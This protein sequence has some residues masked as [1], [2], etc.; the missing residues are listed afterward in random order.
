VAKYGGR[1]ATK[2]ELA[3]THRN[4]PETVDGTPKFLVKLLMEG[5]A[6]RYRRRADELRAIAEQLADQE[7]RATLLEAAQD[8]ERMAAAAD[9]VKST[10][11]KSDGKDT[12][13]KLPR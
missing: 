2:Q 5:K 4:P 12:G 11:G 10:V 8:Y 9:D 7:A 13:Q 6:E 3:P 1:V